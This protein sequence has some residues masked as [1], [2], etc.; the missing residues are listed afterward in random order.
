MDTM[1]AIVSLRD[2]A[3]R[4]S[5]GG[6]NLP[7]VPWNRQ[8]G[9]TAL[10][11]VLGFLKESKLESMRL[12]CF[13]SAPSFSAQRVEPVPDLRSVWTVHRPHDCGDLVLHHPQFT[14][15]G[16][17]PALPFQSEALH[18]SSSWGG[19]GPNVISITAITN[20]SGPSPVICLR[21]VSSLLL[22]MTNT[23]SPAI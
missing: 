15:R 5:G 19:W 11:G 7:Q 1:H 17:F 8:Q 6:A 20:S 22:V 10:Q 9:G 23:S 21:S 16:I 4:N 13:S 18:F 12:P 2:W 3:A 14:F